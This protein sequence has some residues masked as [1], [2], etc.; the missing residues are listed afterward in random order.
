M[1]TLLCEPIKRDARVGDTLI[2][3]LG[4]PDMTVLAVRAVDMLDELA[5]TSKSFQD[6][7][8]FVVEHAH[9]P[10]DQHIESVQVKRHG[11]VYTLERRELQVGDRVLAETDTGLDS[12]MTS[13]VV[14]RHTLN[15]LVATNPAVAAG[16]FFVMV[17]V[18][19]ETK[20]AVPLTSRLDK[21]T[22][23]RDI[24]ERIHHLETTLRAV[25]SQYCTG[26]T[27]RITVE[28]T[29]YRPDHQGSTEP[30][31]FNPGRLA[32]YLEDDIR[33]LRETSERILLGLSGIRTVE[34]PDK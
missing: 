22:Q 10:L 23:L 9:L 27:L 7:D 15:Q 32:A 20:K 33:A 1:K 5:R 31:A 17:P 4:K 12:A 24:E 13:H 6:H 19:T 3:R 26:G 30:L 25:K 34:K 29:D 16:R 8:Y 11:A 14:T 21:L 2:L 18:S 28:T